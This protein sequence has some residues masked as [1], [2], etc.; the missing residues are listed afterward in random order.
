V[1][2]WVHSWYSWLGTVET[3]LID[4]SESVI[5]TTGMKMASVAFMSVD[6]TA[7]AT[8]DFWLWLTVGVLA[9]ESK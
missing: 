4:G 6:L 9:G 7:A 8:V 3:L 5:M 1:T 2:L